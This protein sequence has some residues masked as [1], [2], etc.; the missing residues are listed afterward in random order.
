MKTIITFSISL[1]FVIVFTCQPVQLNA[2]EGMWLFNNLPVKQLKERYGF[3]PTEEWTFHLMRS[4]VRFNSG[5]S[6]SFISSNGL[7]LTNHHVGAETLHKLSS[8]N[9][10]YY[11]DGFLARTFDE[12]L[13][14]PD[15]ELNQLINIVDVTE[16]VKGAVDSSMST[17]EAVEARR[18][19]ILEIEKNATE[20]TGLRSNVI[21]LYGGGRYHL[22]Q[23]KKYT[24]IRLVW[25]PEAAI[26]FFGGDADNFEYP[27]YCLDAC[28]FRVYEDGKPAKVDH[29][30]KWSKSGAAE[31]ELVFVSGNP[32]STSRIYTHAALKYERDVYLPYVMN[33]IR[34]LEIQLQLY[35]Q[36]NAESERRAKDELLGIQN[37]RKARMGMLK[38]LQEPS[39]MKQKL[40][41]EKALLEMM[42]K[43]T[44][45]REYR[46]AW[47]QIEDVQKAKGEMLGKALTLRSPLFDVAEH[48]VRMAIEDSKPNQERIPTYSESNRESLERQLF[49]PAPI[50]PDLERM[51]IADS[52]ARIMELRGGDDPWVK[53][54]LGDLS[55]EQ[56]AE[57]MVENSQLFEVDA[58]KAIAEDGMDAIKSSEDPIIQF[59]LKVDDYNRELEKQVAQVQEKET[60]AYA[61]VAEALFATKGT[62]TYPDA[63]FSLRLAY[64]TVK[65]YEENGKT[66][67]ART[68]M[69]GAFQHE[70]VHGAV[71]P[72]KLPGSWH[73]AKQDLDFDIPLNFICTADIIGGN[74]GSP[75]VNKAGEMVGLIFDGN[76]QSLPGDY[77][78]SDVQNRAISVHSSAIRHAIKVVYGAEDLA[79]QLG[80]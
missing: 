29:F 79:A 62:S 17:A 74:S 67:P 27:R 23:F 46:D 22:Y 61:Q 57:N 64:G 4:S 45:L 78:F 80:N 6:G 63:T 52:L 8:E 5:G 33:Y 31:N 58:R 42:S 39:F 14:A 26:A 15:L 32:G 59:V 38:G 47:K 53:K 9:N 60:Q 1:A 16:K 41:E 25:S 73:Q 43:R 24:D 3:E 76:I 71:V 21:T 50:Y 11:S 36:E 34:R 72:W 77:Y 48:L 49:S 66:I 51:K 35:S 75:V 37:A 44:D 19:T 20:E 68:T 12:E 18:A 65:T 7:V 70:Q 55:P 2:D 69:G 30:L 28:I 54:I 13:K 10:D 56:L 40:S